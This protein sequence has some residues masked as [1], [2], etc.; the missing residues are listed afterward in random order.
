MEA[1][2]NCKHNSTEPPLLAV[3]GEQIMDEMKSR[4]K[5]AFRTEMTAAG[6]YG[7]FARQ[8]GKTRP[9]LGERFAKAS[10]EEHMHGRLFRQLYRNSFGGDIGGEKFWMGAG[11]MAALFMTPVPLKAKLKAVSRKEAEAVAMITGELSGSQETALARV[12]KRILP[13][14]ESHAKIYDEVFSLQ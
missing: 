13:D 8:Y 6:L 9:G 5:K 1:F 7:V 4:V 2:S 12:L 3:N 11:R 14:E 10:E